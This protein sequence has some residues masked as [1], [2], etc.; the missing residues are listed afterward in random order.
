MM[1]GTITINWLNFFFLMRMYNYLY[2][3]LKKS[4]VW[5]LYSDLALTVRG[6]ALDVRI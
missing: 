2:N 1:Q 4:N 5:I 6:S 3:L